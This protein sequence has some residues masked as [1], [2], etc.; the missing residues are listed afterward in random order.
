MAD[1]ENTSVS[2]VSL[3]SKATGV[4]GI[5]TIIKLGLVLNTGVS[6]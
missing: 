6:A 4:L 1:V 2:S 5:S 3:T